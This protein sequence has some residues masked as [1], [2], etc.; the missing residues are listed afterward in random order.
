MKNIQ[1]SYELPAGI[2]Q[3]LAMRNLKLFVNGQN[4]LTF[5]QMKN[6]DPE[7]DLTQDNIFAYPQVKT[8]TAG[9]NV[10]F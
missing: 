10:T 5:T 2:T 4:L 1:L 3:K 8:F 6:W 7:K 9:L